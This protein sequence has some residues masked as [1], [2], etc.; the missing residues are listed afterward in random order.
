MLVPIKSVR[1]RLYLVSFG[2][3]KKFQDTSG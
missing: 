1:V 2:L 3:D